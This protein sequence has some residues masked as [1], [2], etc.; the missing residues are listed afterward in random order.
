MKKREEAKVR[1]GAEKYEEKKEQ[2]SWKPKR[3]EIERK[4]ER[5]RVE[6]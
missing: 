2:A 5:K 4:S 3:R 1:E 6:K